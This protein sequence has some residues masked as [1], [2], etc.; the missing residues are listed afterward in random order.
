M[1]T[2]LDDDSSCDVAPTVIDHDSDADVDDGRDDDA[3]IQSNDDDDDHDAD[4]NDDDDADDPDSESHEAAEV[5]GEG[6][7]IDSFGVDAYAMARIRA[8]SDIEVALLQEQPLT[9][10][11]IL[12]HCKQE[13]QHVRD[14]FGGK[15]SVFKIGITTD[16]P[17]RMHF[18]RNENLRYMRVIHAS[19]SADLTNMLESALIQ[20]FWHLSGS[21]NYNSGGEGNVDQRPGPYYTYVVAARADGRYR[22][23]S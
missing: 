8:E 20:A 16:P 11:N 10:W 21:R 7:Y 4:D 9:C 23:G 5:V 6:V 19:Q 14:A 22:I 17:N 13:I 2:L 12:Q 3:R 15:V 1:D 18:Y